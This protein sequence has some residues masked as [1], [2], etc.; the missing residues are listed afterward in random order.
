MRE[1]APGAELGRY[2]L[3]EVAGKGGMGVVY[4]ARQQRPDR[5]VAL[6]VITPTLASDDTFRARF[7]R[8]SNTAAQIEHPNV[9]PVYE[10]DEEDGL[11]YIVMRYV[12]GTDLG[13]VIER[14]RR[15]QPDRA[16][17]LIAQVADA[18]DAA[19]SEG[20]VHRDVKPAN[21]LVTGAPPREHLYLTDFGLTKHTSSESGMT[22]SGMIVGTLDYIAPEQVTGGVVDARTDVYALGCVLYHALTGSV[23]YPRETNPAKLY[24][25]AHEPPPRLP[26]G[27]PTALQDVIDRAMCKQVD[28]RYPSAGDLGR[29]AMQAAENR[30]PLTV[31]RSV[32]VGAAAPSTARRD[33]PPPAPPT[34]PAPERPVSQP[35]PPSAQT[36]SAS[37]SPPPPPAPLYA[38]PSPQ[39]G[40]FIPYAAWH[41]RA[42][43]FLVDA[44][45]VVGLPGLLGT[46]VTAAGG[47][48]EDA[49]SAGAGVWF[50][51]YLIWVPLYGAFT[52]GRGGPHN[53][54]TIGHQIARVRVVRHD[55]RP[56]TGGWAAAREL[57]KWVVF[58]FLGWIV[59][60][61]PFLNFFN[62]L[63]DPRQTT[64]HDRLT[65]SAVVRA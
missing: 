24:A 61:L 25:Q 5:V 51:A 37:A 33:A 23:P 32:A 3:E 42:L 19:H 30:P 22:Q 14:E 4:R 38:P 58:A 60:V 65:S 17:R 7:E 50:V 16:A 62:P 26:T 21:V 2:T 35:Q 1:L 59:L 15:L 18:L 20:L 53:G 11:L 10:V 39:Q 44:L 63:W 8:E 13:G 6:K 12:E 64:Y 40:S 57:L 47:S 52:L 46:I 34:A 29:A 55:G 36:A 43:G 9:I 31:E 28:G 41:S 54:Q 49:G 27:L 56:V 45:I 48:S